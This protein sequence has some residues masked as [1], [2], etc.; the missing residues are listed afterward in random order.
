MR[1][2]QRAA[3]TPLV[4]T[5]LA[6]AYR[7]VRLMGEGAMGGIYEAR[8]LRLDK[9]VAIKVLARELAANGEALLR[10]H[11]EAEITSSLGHPH[12]I[13]VFDFGSTDG[14]QPFL[15]M[16]YLEGED[17][18][19]RLGRANKLPVPAAI[20]IT[21]QV[22]AA[23]AETH[24]KGIVHRD[25]K[26]AN[27][28]LSRI[29][30][31][32]FAKVLDFGIS[33]VRAASTSLTNASTLM[34]T[35]MYM[36]PEQAKGASELDHWTDQWA[37]ACIAYEMLTGRPPFIGDDTAALLYMVVHED[38]PPPSQINP[39]LP[40]EIDHVIKRALHK[41]QTER[42][43]HVTAFARA[44][45][46]AAAGKMVSIEPGSGGTGVR[47]VAAGV[48]LTPVEAAATMAGDASMF[49]ARPPKRRAPRL[50]LLGAV[51]L[52]AG[53]GVWLARGPLRRPP[54]AP[55][56]TGL[57]ALG[58]EAAAAGKPVAEPTLPTSPPAPSE[59]AAA[60]PDEPTAVDDDTDSPAPTV[61]MTKKAAS[62]RRMV[63]RAT[64]AKQASARAA[65]EASA[66]NAPATAPAPMKRKLINEL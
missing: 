60:A 53:G 59:A 58:N 34:G 25:L 57:P 62:H 24:A 49:A 52:L 23:L 55:A 40:S 20:R 4:G 51:A 28:F 36:A 26:P 66:R 10:F 44:L 35:P 65:R 42:F 43:P 29:Q 2:E 18:A 5:T 63:R 27:V 61:M 38:P 47:T 48:A 50:V 14:G 16:E 21:K 32:D 64:S 3:A 7:I 19:N 39:D 11:R 45:E 33:K 13:T 31:E 56:V 8:Q 6:N 15:V 9:R 37:L 12:I 1:P 41:D 46:A 30:G 54:P 22:A 17:L